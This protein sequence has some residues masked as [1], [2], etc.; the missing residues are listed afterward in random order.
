[1]RECTAPAKVNLFLH[2]TGK[3]ADGY[4]VLE[5]MVA[6]AGVHDR[7]QVAP[8][9]RLTLAVTGRFAGQLPGD[10]GGNI[11]LRAAQ[12]LAEAAGVRQGAAL[13]LEKQLPVAAGI[14]GGSADAAAVLRLLTRLW[15]IA[16]PEEEML[17]LALSLG[18][19]VPVCYRGVTAMMRGIGEQLTPLPKLPALPAVLVNPLCAVPT[20]EVFRRNSSPFSPA[21]EVGEVP[22]S[23]EGLVEF[24][25]SMHND[26]EPAAIAVQP[27]VGEL[28]EMIAAETG[29]LLSRMS[30]S[31][32][33]C[34]GIFASEAEAQAAARSLRKLQPEWW[35]EATVIG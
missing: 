15:D 22:A 5:S 7:L 12:M 13:V 34:F 2:I 1:M 10:T 23:L 11:V 14:G 6:F 31:G 8:A 29:C 24:I 19:D 16:L 4:H 30:G 3:R 9:D 35:V 33:T 25:R 27:L 20:A 17:A 26:L 21:Q 18:A 32:A 28:L